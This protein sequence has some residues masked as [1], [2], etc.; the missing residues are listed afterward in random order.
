[1]NLGLL[2]LLINKFKGRKIVE[3]EPKPTAP[4]PNII[5]PQVLELNPNLTAAKFIAWVEPIAKELE[6]NT[7]VSATVAMAQAAHESRYG[8]SQLARVAC[9]LFGIKATDSWKKAGKMIYSIPT[10]EVI[11]GKSIT[12]NAHFRA[13][14][15]WNESFEDWA[16][17]MQ[18]SIYHYAFSAM[19]SGNPK[20][21]IREIAKAGYA[22]DPRYADKVEKMFDYIKNGGLA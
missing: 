11:E 16:N 12:V 6:K 18:K 20:G 15:S 2:T 10:G 4:T 17:L 5:T 21:A 14:D 7:G 19:K 22:T 13:Y 9:N 8:N 3:S 1:M